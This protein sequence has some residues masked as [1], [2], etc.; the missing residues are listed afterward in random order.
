MLRASRTIGIRSKEHT[1]LRSTFLLTL[2]EPKALAESREDTS[3]AESAAWVCLLPSAMLSGI[4]TLNLL[5]TD[6]SVFSK[7]NRSSLY[8]KTEKGSNFAHYGEPKLRWPISS[9][10]SAIYFCTIFSR[11][12]F[13]SNILQFQR[14]TSFRAYQIVSCEACEYPIALNPFIRLALSTL[15]AGFSRL[16]WY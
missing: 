13:R 7:H 1:L 11:N 6:S 9:L 15:S 5:L 16:S 10:K 12:F 14:I 4:A 3:K 8:R 2:F